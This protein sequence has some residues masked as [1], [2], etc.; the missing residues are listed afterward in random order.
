MWHL[1]MFTIDGDVYAF[2][3]EKTEGGITVRVTRN[4]L[5]K[6]NYIRKSMNARTSGV[7]IMSTLNYPYSVI[8]RTHT[9]TQ[10]RVLNWLDCDRFA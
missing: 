3:L 5:P 1:K 7:M 10:D 8:Q 2:V 4:I 9:H 6:D